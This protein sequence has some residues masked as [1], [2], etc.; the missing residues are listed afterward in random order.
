MSL[1]TV[2]DRITSDVYTL[3]GQNVDVQALGVSLADDLYGYSSFF[4][5]KSLMLARRTALVEMV[6]PTY[7]EQLID[8]IRMILGS[9]VAG[10]V[11][12]IFVET[13]YLFRFG[14]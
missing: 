4:L 8:A 12:P 13:K 5:S 11:P 6:V 1:G 10:N 3:L 2:F 14:P 7:P 9:A